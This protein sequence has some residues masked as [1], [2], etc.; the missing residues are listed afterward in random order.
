MNTAAISLLRV[1]LVLI[2]I[3]ALLGQVWVVPAFVAESVFAFPEVKLLAVPYSITVILGIA[4]VQVALLAIWRLL[5]MVERKEIFSHAAFR[6]VDVI[7]WSAAI[8][9]AL[10]LFLGIHLLGVMQLGG[11]G[12]LLACA[13]A[14]ICGTGF[15]LLM[16]VMKGL[17]R[18][19]TILEDE[20]AE[21]V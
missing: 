2:F 13:G 5:A 15:A 9:T 11:P 14:T 7:I 17:L 6:W 4:C 16:I 12:V 10:A 19:A 18:G 3:G 21:V 20:M 1:T 8:A